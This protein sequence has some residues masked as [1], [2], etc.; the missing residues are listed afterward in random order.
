[1]AG[2]AMCGFPLQDLLALQP[3]HQL[4]FLELLL[5]QLPAQA[6]RRNGTCLVSSS[7]GASGSGALVPLPAT[8][9]LP[10]LHLLCGSQ[11]GE[12]RQLARRWAL[13]RLAA[14]GAF[15]GHEEEVLVWVDLLPRYGGGQ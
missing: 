5:A 10:V 14:T 11:H 3:H 6:S 9:L 1:M 15:D 8:L 4:L 12:V 7:P 13:A 2:L